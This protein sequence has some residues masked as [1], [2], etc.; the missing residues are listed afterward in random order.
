MRLS[1]FRYFC[2]RLTRSITAFTEILESSPT[3]KA[4]Q[5]C[6]S[7]AGG[8]DT[9]A[10]QSFSMQLL[11][12]LPSVEGFSGL[13]EVKVPQLCRVAASRPS[14]IARSSPRLARASPNTPR[15]RA[16]G[17][18]SGCESTMCLCCCAP[19]TDPK[20]LIQCFSSLDK[21]HAGEIE[22]FI[23]SA[24]PT[25]MAVVSMSCCSR[26]GVIDPVAT[27]MLPFHCIAV[28]S[29]VNSPNPDEP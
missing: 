18:G 9:L 24:K 3:R 29:Q 14:G 1:S 11:G 16:Y 5:R 15:C 12:E 22:A 8:V 19:Q 10:S 17:R 13:L 2:L 28:N 27:K 4:Y 26:I 7:W 25:L 21:A 20:V 23:S 6:P